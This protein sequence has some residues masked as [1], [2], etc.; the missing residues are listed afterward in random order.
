MMI[1]NSLENV[2]PDSSPH[3]QKVVLQY[4]ELAC[5]PYLSDKQQEQLAEILERATESEVLTFWIAEIDHI[6][7]HKL[8]LLNPEERTSYQNQQA[9]LR[10]YLAINSEFKSENSSTQN[11]PKQ[12]GKNQASSFLYPPN[13]RY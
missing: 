9:L 8:G 7:A 11:F 10:E 5:L 12:E 3:L 6:I 2:L 13:C 4:W 1:T